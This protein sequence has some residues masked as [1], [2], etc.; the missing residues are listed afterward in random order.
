MDNNS[1]LATA[2]NFFN[3]AVSRKTFNPIIILSQ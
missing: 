1:E 2:A 3:M